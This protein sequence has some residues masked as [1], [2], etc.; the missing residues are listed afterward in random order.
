MKSGEEHEEQEE[1]EEWEELEEQKVTMKA[2]ATQWQHGTAGGNR[3][4][5]AKHGYHS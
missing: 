5:H 3:A 4:T 2:K 1:H